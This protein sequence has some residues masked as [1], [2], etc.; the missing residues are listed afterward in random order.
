MSKHVRQIMDAATVR[1]T[2]I[3]LEKD[4]SK[5]T[6]DLLTFQNVIGRQ[7]CLPEHFQKV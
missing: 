7:T 3:V 5:D 1:Q 4:E 6:G 2:N